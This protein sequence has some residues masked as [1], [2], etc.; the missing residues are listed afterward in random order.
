MCKLENT[1]SPTKCYISSHKEFLNY[2]KNYWKNNLKISWAK[3]LCNETGKTQMNYGSFYF[4]MYLCYDRYKNFNWE[5]FK[6]SMYKKYFKIRGVGCGYRFLDGEDGFYPE[7]GDE[8]YSVK[9]K[10]WFVMQHDWLSHEGRKKHHTMYIV[11]R[12]PVSNTEYF[13]RE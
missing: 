5:L 11:M 3:T 1:T 7:E 10:K 12:R 9:E 6:V 13:L 8:Y 4:Y 2:I